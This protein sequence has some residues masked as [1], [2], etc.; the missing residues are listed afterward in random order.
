MTRK[1]ISTPPAPTDVPPAADADEA[2]EPDDAT[3][4]STVKWSA[5]FDGTTAKGSIALEPVTPFVATLV[6]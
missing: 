6:E 5:S 1:I 2:T 3:E 4:P